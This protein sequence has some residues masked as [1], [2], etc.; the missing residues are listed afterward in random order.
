MKNNNLLMKEHK[1]FERQLDLDLSDLQIFLLLKYN[2]I[3]NCT[4]PGITPLFQK[5]E[6]SEIF[7]ETKSISTIKWKEYNVFCLYHE[8]LYT[9]LRHIK[10]LILEASE[11][12]ELDFNKEKYYIQGWFNVVEASKGKLDWHGHGERG[13]GF[14]GYY[15]VNA[16]PS[17]T[18]YKINGGE[19]VENINLNNRLILSEIGH[20]H[21]MGDWNWDGPRI[22]IAF[23]VWPLR[24]VKGNTPENHFFPLF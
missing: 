11:Y 19:I 18:Y 16:A 17:S 15:C 5:G 9:L 14:H 10:D 13:L 24:N 7:L 3:S 1:F 22:T 8:G 6:D 4:M 12:Y 23:D 20:D 2:E 21:A